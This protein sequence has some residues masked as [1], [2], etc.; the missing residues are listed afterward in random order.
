LILGKYAILSFLETV[1]YI[2]ILLKQKKYSEFQVFI[3][4][5]R[6]VLKQGG[7]SMSSWSKA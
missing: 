3:Q 6:F 5:K 2:A 1:K 4:R 7:T